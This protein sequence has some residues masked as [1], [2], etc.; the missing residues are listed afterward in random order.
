[1]MISVLVGLGL[2]VPF[3][4]RLLTSYGRGRGELLYSQSQP[5]RPCSSSNPE[6]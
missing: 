3:G 6:G 1:M 5:V 2:T 4:N